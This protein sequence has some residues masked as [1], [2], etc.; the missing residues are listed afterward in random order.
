MKKTLLLF[1]FSI[2]WLSGHAQTWEG[3]DAGYS[4][5]VNIIDISLVDENVIWSASRLGDFSGNQWV[6]SP[7]NLLTKSI[8]GGQTW[9][10]IEISVPSTSW[11][12]NQIHALDAE[13]AWV[14]MYS[15]GA[16]AVYKTTDG[17]LTWDE[18]MATTKWT[19]FVHFWDADKG[20]AAADPIDGYFEVY[21]TDDG[22]E[23]WE[24]VPEANIPGLDLGAEFLSS[25]SFDVVGS[26]IWW[27]TNRGRIFHSG[28]FGQTWSAAETVIGGFSYKW[29]EGIDFQDEMHGIAHTANY[30]S[31]PFQSFLIFTE[32]GGQTWALQDVDVTNYSI[33]AAKYIPGSPFLMKTSRASN[34][35]GPYLTSLSDDHGM[36]WMDI[37]EGTPIMDFEF[38]S[39]TLG[40][41]GK[42]KNADD[43]A[44]M[45]EYVGDPIISGILGQKPLEA[46]VSVF[47]NPATDYVSLEMETETATDFVVLLNDMNGKLVW[48]KRFP[49]TNLISEKFGLKNLP[50]GIYTLTIGNTEGVFSEK[51]FVK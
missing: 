4:V 33:F 3:S 6:F 44:L 42:F 24:R 43:P 31:A 48:K 37:D 10:E 47:P 16:G 50:D 2:I 49:N 1:S 17:G 19:G 22:G 40:W 38:L 11:G 8:D 21:T 25:N 36:T 14:A 5:P 7:S 12:V 23:N 27:G 28:D 18:Q 46:T 39:P 29:V 41:G 26:N 34:G 20:I 45:Y 51:I 35:D 9:T 13:T 15:G 30:S 32:D